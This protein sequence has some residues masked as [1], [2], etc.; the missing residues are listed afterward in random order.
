MAQA[1]LPGAAD[2]G[3]LAVPRAA[4]LTSSVT[5]ANSGPAT[6]LTLSSLDGSWS[7]D[8]TVAKGSAVVVEVPAKVAAVR[9]SAAGSSSGQPR[10]PSGLAAAT[11]VTAQAGGQLAGTLTSTVPAQPNAAAQAQRRMLL[12]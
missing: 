5:V 2:S 4:S 10:T 11:I 1:A 12:G 9:L 3:L 6:S 8:V 7:Q